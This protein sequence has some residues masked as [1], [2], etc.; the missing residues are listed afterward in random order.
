MLIWKKVE[1]IS[2]ECCSSYKKSDLTRFY[3]QDIRTAVTTYVI[4]SHTWKSI[5]HMAKQIRNFCINRSFLLNIHY[6]KQFK[7]DILGISFLFPSYK[8]ENTFILSF[9]SP[10][11]KAEG[12]EWE[13]L[14]SHQI[15]QHTEIPNFCFLK[16]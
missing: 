11:V 15:L 12:F 4:T 8:V 16:Y 5:P 6:Q 10:N 1:K 3:V 14:L 9:L 2:R 7:K 13:N